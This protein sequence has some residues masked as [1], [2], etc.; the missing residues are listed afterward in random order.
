MKG[1]STFFLTLADQS[2]C[3]VTLFSLFEDSDDAFD[4]QSDEFGIL[5][6]YRDGG[7]TKGGFLGMAGNGL[8]NGGHCS[9]D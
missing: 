1:P 6:P 2:R 9:R 8:N 3:L 7:L 5:S 4:V